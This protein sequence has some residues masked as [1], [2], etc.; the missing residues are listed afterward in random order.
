M[1]KSSEKLRHEAAQRSLDRVASTWRASRTTWFDGTPQSIEARLA[2]TNRVL[3]VARSG[4]TP[5]HLGLTVEAENA[6][7]EL[8][9]ERHRLMEDF[10]DDSA[11][12]FKGSKRVAGD[13]DPMLDRQNALDSARAD[14]N[15]REFMHQHL[16]DTGPGVGDEDEED[17]NEPA[18]R[19][20]HEPD[21]DRFHQDWSRYQQQEKVNREWQDAVRG[22]ERDQWGD[23]IGSHHEAKERGLRECV[24][25]GGALSGEEDD[26][27]DS[28]CLTCG[29]S[30]HKEGY[31]V[32]LRTAAEDYSEGV[33][34]LSR[35]L[36]DR[37]LNPEQ[38]HRT[39]QNEDG[40]AGIPGGWP[41]ELS[42][43]LNDPYS[44][45]YA[46]SGHMPYLTHEDPW[47][48]AGN[49]FYNAGGKGEG[50]FDDGWLDYSADIPHKYNDPE[51]YAAYHGGQ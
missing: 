17:L 2:E 4:Y 35:Y 9:A 12:A 25:C 7:R 3:A 34:N 11:R 38:Y 39:Y 47:E 8:L 46:A 50:S 13:G 1:F 10:L 23:I 45:G 42:Q 24:N 30:A 29:K 43:H 6:R 26:D 27:K 48:A 41:K 36:G 18:F 20:G 40:Q 32:A 44:A 19:P 49:D 15:Y 22:K 5:A 21:Y 33:D 37:L 16:N 28:E 14:G 51:G 31:R